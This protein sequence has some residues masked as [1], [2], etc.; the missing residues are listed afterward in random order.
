MTTCRCTCTAYGGACDCRHD[1]LTQGV[2]KGEAATLAAVVKYLRTKQDTP[3][4]D[5][6]GIR[7]VADAIER[8]EWRP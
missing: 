3:V 7:V 1:G 5:W 2:A 4:D 8:G 6:G